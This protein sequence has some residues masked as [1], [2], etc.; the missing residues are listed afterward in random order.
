MPG[1]GVRTQLAHLRYINKQ[2]EGAPAPD[3]LHYADLSFQLRYQIRG[4]DIPIVFGLGPIMSVALTKTKLGVTPDGP[5]A[6]DKYHMLD[7]GLLPSV[8]FYLGEH[9]LLGL[10][11]IV[12][13]RNMYVQYDTDKFSTYMTIAGISI[14]Y[15][16]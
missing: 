5:S 16:F 14:G 12:G 11:A 1:A 10:E 9:W 4:I 7:Y 3:F 6:K 8:S 2:S 15:R 13:L